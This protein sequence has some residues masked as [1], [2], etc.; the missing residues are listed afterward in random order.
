MAAVTVVKARPVTPVG[1]EVNDGPGFSATEDL[2][3]GNLLVLGASGWSKTPTNTVEPH[4][5]CLKDCP[6][7]F[8]P[9][10]GIQGEM[11]GF[12]GLTPGAPLYPSGSTAGGIDT[13]A[14]T[15]YNAATT[16]AVAVPAS[17]R[18]RAV[19]TTRIRFNFI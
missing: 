13:T 19:S 3:A 10:V 15:F 1:Y 14:T 4:G 17:A 6:S 16:P 7:G 11:D 8:T 5:I 2:V 9:D 12:S 18:I